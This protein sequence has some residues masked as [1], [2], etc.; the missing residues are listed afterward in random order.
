MSGGVDKKLEI[1]DKIAEILKNTFNLKDELKEKIKNYIKGKSHIKKINDKNFLVKGD[2]E[3]NL[4]NVI[5]KAGIVLNIPIKEPIVWVHYMK[6]YFIFYFLMIKNLYY[7][8]GLQ[9][10]NQN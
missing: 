7:Y 8:M 4:T 3:E 10:I 2:N 5:G 6:L 9:V 1:Y